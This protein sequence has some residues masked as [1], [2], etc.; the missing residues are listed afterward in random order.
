MSD[1]DDTTR[2]EYRIATY[3][4]PSPFENA[5]FAAWLNEFGREGWRLVS[6]H[7][8]PSVNQ[9]ASFCIFERPAIENG[10]EK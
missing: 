4:P 3:Y 7:S 8:N 10:S 9:F 2:F 1:A 5:D 6:A